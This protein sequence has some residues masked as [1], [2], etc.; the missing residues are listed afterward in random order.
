M[1]FFSTPSSMRKLLPYT[2][3]FNKPYKQKS[4]GFRSVLL[5]SQSTVSYSV[6]K[7]TLWTTHNTICSVKGM[8]LKIIFCE[9]T[10]SKEMGPIILDALIAHHTPTLTLCKSS[11][12]INEVFSVDQHFCD[13]AHSLGRPKVSS[14]NRKSAGSFSP[15]RVGLTDR[16]HRGR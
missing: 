10:V 12:W 14:P 4:H 13:F 8:V 5:R 1:T 2:L 16:R 11:L 3:S 6:N 15:T 7:I 9:L